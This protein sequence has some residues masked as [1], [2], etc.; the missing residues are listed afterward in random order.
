MRRVLV[1]GGAGFIGSHFVKRI[2]KAED[3]T[4]VIVLDALTYAGHIENLGTAFLSDK[5]RFVHGSIQ[6]AAV[7]N[8][9]MGAGTTDVVHFAA[10]SHVDR[11]Y[12][13]AAGFLSTN[14]L[15]TQNLVDAAHR[16]DI[17][18][19]V[20]VSTDEVYGPL[21]QGTATEEAPLRPTVPYAVS[22]A[23]SDLVAL[24]A[25]QTLGLPVCVTRSSNNYGPYQ[26]PEKIIPL[27]VTRLLRSLPVT[28]HD[29]G[30]HVR[31]W[32]HVEDNCAGI[33]A[34]LRHGRPGEIYNLGGGTD[35][36]SKELTGHLL[37]LCDA[38]W[39]AV[40]Y[41]P[42]RPANDVRYS[43]D[44]AKA[45]DQLGYRPQHRLEDGLA[46]T[47]EWYRRNP[48]RWAPLAAAG[49]RTVLSSARPLLAPL[50]TPRGH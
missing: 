16:H 47:A 9:L 46:E 2:I 1:T 26:H 29:R 44:W 50:E 24:G 8:A 45:R 5:L 35:L 30:Q 6:D 10:E 19:F 17:E 3:V 22:K 4:H 18:K 36:S 31:N 21:A 39:D 38:T 15:G 40:T 14:V 33:E 23:A 11:S 42:D 32:L 37:N 27:F 34:V 49:L 13:A 12:H 41:I 7:V 43:I 25:H 28:L 20:H 48:D